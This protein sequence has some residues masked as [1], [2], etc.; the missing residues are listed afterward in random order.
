MVDDNFK[1]IEILDKHS[2]LINYGRDQAAN[3]NDKVRIISIGPAVIDPETNEN[4]GTLNS[5]KAILTVV[6]VYDKF[7]LC[8]NIETTTTNVLTSPLSRFE[9]KS[10]Q[11]KILNVDEATISN[12]K[13]PDDTLIKIGDIVEI[14]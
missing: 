4:L 1:V 2:V 13:I 5:V 3:E 9:T 8:Q 11:V 6:T 10:T 14:L 12:K 7:S